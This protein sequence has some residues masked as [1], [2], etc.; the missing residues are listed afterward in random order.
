M[1]VTL[2]HTLTSSLVTT[3][4][5]DI[6]RFI[7]FLVLNRYLFSILLLFYLLS[8]STAR[9]T[10]LS[11]S[12]LAQ[13]SIVFRPWITASTII[14]KALLCELFAKE[15]SL[16]IDKEWGGFNF[17]NNWASLVSSVCQSLFTWNYSPAWARQWRIINTMAVMSIDI[18]TLGYLG[19]WSQ[20]FCPFTA[21]LFVGE[22]QG[23]IGKIQRLDLQ[24]GPLS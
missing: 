12:W 5:L 15:N 23:S 2:S 3:M 10:I 11:Q 18:I 6:W 20:Q 16:L 14:D 24:K 21:K 13:M 9:S 7:L 1:W 8:A 19:S 17:N 22:K 4:V